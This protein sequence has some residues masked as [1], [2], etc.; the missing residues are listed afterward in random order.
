[1]YWSGKFIG[2]V[3]GYILG[4]PFGAVA[5]LVVGQYF[6]L[7]RATQW[8]QVAPGM[9]RENAQQAFFR[10]TFLIM[11]HIAKADG[12]VSESEIQAAKAAMRNMMLSPQM[13]KEAIRLFTEG[14]QS[15]FSLDV[16]I[17]DLLFACQHQRMLL[18]MFIEIQIQAAAAAGGGINQIKLRILD[19]LCRR[20]GFDVND[21]YVFESQH[22]RH[23]QQYRQRAKPPP[24]IDKVT[25]AYKTLNIDKKATDAEVKKA[26]R[27]QLSQNHPDKLVAKGLPEEMIKLANQK[28]HEI[29]QAYDIIAKSR[30][31]K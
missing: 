4:G 17:D 12:R 13:R 30:G 3:L 11:G 29:K 27:K 25:R 1:V 26:Y 10:T 2:A 22:H 8:R 21:F 28:T 20:L 16:A 15:G 18:H 7:G 14:K 9:K 6:D 24:K 23:Y 19:Y 5:G 31:I